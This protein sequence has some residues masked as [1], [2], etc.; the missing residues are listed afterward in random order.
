[1]TT[2]TAQAAGTTLYRVLWRW[3]FYA[4]LY[5]FLFLVMLSITGILMLISGPLEDMQYRDRYFVTAGETRVLPSDQL[6]AVQEAY[7]HADVVSYVPPRAKDRSS[8]F[9]VLPHHDMSGEHVAHWALPTISVFVNPYNGKVL[10]ELDPN[11]TLYNWAV[12]IHGTFLMGDVGDY[13]IEI[14]A[15]FAVLLI[16]SGLIMWWPRN[17]TSWRNT[18][19]PVGGMG[20]GRVFWRNLHMVIGAWTSVV[21]LFFLLSGLTWTLVW[22]AKFTQAWSSLPGEQFQGPVSTETHETLNVNGHHEVPWG[23]EQTPLPMSGSA[24]GFP[25]I[26]AAAGIDLDSVVTYARDNGFTNFRVAIPNTDANVWTVAAATQSGDITDPRKD[27]VLHIDRVTG[28]I[29]GD[30]TFQDYSFLGKVMA[31]SI[32]LH[33]GDLGVLNLVANGLFC[34]LIILLAWSGVYMWWQRR[35]G[36]SLRLIPPP[37]PG[38]QQIWRAAFVGMLVMSLMFPLVALT[39]ISL[40]ILDYLFLSRIEVIKAAVK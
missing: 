5:V 29:L 38:N 30:I 35:S 37:M 1:M 17:G 27:R 7:P 21:M 11:G 19:W 22:G 3:H 25:G 8:L 28:N 31:A 20:Q 26:D 18:L 24:A 9:A 13:L 39:L 36:K 34:G 6:A 10:G 4:G 16:V 12:E 32:P 33:Q 14:A 15:G 23:I 2:S 40:V